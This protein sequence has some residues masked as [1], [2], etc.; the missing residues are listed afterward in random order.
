MLIRFGLV[1]GIGFLVDAG[2]LTLLV[3]GFTWHHYSARAVSFAAAVTITWALNRR[4]VF[5]RTDDGRREYAQYFGV[6]TV[7][8]AIN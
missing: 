2:I 8:A 3:N 6:Q 1:G 7:G 4:W 5:V